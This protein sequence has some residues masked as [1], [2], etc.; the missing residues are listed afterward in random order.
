MQN[1]EHETANEAEVLRHELQKLK[2][3]RIITLMLAGILISL[4]VII[5]L[6]WK[7]FS[8]ITLLQEDARTAVGIVVLSLMAPI[9]RIIWDTKNIHDISKRITAEDNNL[10]D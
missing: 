9:C 3:D 7:I 2:D 10:A 4:E 6:G 1:K 5:I 8:P